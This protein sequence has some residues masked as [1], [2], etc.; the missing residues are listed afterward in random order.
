MACAIFF[1]SFWFFGGFICCNF[2]AFYG[3]FHLNNALFLI[4]MWLFLHE[5]VGR[6]VQGTKFAELASEHWCTMISKKESATTGDR[7]HT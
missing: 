5:W 3:F 7:A 1:S 4:L 6:A 2:V